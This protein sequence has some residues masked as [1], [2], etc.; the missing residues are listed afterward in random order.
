MRPVNKD[1]LLK[2]DFTVFENE[3]NHLN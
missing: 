2:T 3:N 1:G